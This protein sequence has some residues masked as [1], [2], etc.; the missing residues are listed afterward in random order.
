MPHLL[1][2]VRTVRVKEAKD[3]ADG[4]QCR[5]EVCP[6]LFVPLPL[7]LLFFLLPPRHGLVFVF[8]RLF[9]ALPLEHLL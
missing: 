8:L 5:I 1:Q 6:L 2:R 9:L 3:G 7:V 4:I